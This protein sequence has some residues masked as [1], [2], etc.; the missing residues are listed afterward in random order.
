MSNVRTVST[1]KDVA[2]LA[3]VSTS[4]VSHVVNNDRYVSPEIRARVD[5]AIQTLQYVP[6]ALGR[7]LK[8]K[9]TKTLAML[10]TSSNNPF[11]SEVIRGVERSCYELG[12]NLILCNTE[13]NVE[14]MINSIEGLLQR[15]VDGIVFMCSETQAITPELFSRYPSLPMVMM[16]WSPISGL[17]DIIQD[18]SLLGGSIAT[19]HLIAKG[20]R[21]I[22]CITGRLDNT[23]ALLRLQG[24][25]A[26]LRN[27]DFAILPDYQVEGDF[28]FASG[29]QAMQQLLALRSPPDAVF[30]CND[31]MAVG[32][33]QALYQAGLK[34]KDDIGLIGY[35]D[36]EISHYLTPPLTTIHQP[37]EELGQLA[38]KTLLKRRQNPKEQL[39]IISLTPTLVERQ[40]A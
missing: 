26:A 10:I 23:Q 37:K 18:N 25:Q 40:S 20:Y 11:I 29:F 19:N 21:R 22:A 8:R 7:N 39:Q 6:S 16:D 33:Y 17:C 2:K 31:A 34:V 14:R 3:G 35:D 1:M 36:I 32:A 30:C 15:S 13:D 27:A 9:E 4:T 38:V 24:Y 5:A 28:E 12:Y